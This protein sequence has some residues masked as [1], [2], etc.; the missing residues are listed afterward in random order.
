[1][2]LFLSIAVLASTPVATQRNEQPAQ[3]EKPHNEI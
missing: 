3:A 2:S 1:M